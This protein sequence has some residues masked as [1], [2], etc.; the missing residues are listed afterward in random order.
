[1][2]RFSSS[3]SAIVGNASSAVKG[4]NTK[5]GQDAIAHR[6]GRFVRLFVYEFHP[7]PA[8]VFG[9]RPLQWHD[10]N[11]TNYVKFWSSKTLPAK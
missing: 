8:I 10:I 6:E 1:M 11:W 9:K 5:T 2:L 4:I 3:V 7:T